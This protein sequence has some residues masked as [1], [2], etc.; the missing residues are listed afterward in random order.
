MFTLSPLYKISIT[1][2]ISSTL[3]FILKIFRTQ[4]QPVIKNEKVSLFSPKKYK[5]S[6]ANLLG[7]FIFLL[8]G[9]SNFS[10]KSCT[11]ALYVISICLYLK[12]TRFFLTIFL[13]FSCMNSHTITITVRKSIFIHLSSEGPLV[14]H[15]RQ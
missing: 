1:W 5:D 10:L 2:K 4:A 15:Q 13:L 3:R 6:L 14:Q 12:S 11:C 8:L 7:F 9:S